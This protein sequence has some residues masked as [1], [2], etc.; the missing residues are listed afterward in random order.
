MFSVGLMMTV[1]Q[2]KHVALCNWYYI[3]LSMYLLLCFRRWYSYIFATTQRDDLCQVIIFYLRGSFQKFCTLYEKTKKMNLFYKINLQAFNVIYIVLYQGGLT[4]GKVLYSCLDA[5]FL[6]R[7]ITQVTEPTR[8]W[9]V[10]KIEETTP[11]ET[12]QKHWGGV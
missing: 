9:L 11:W 8:F 12:L 10:P 6:M 7:L 5:S 1:S 4:F 2:S 3:L